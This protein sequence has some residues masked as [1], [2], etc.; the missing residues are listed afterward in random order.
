MTPRPAS[1]PRWLTTRR[2]RRPDDDRA[3]HP[4]AG[5]TTSAARGRGEG[6]DRRGPTHRR[7]RCGR[8]LHAQEAVELVKDE[9][10]TRFE[11][12]ER[13]DL[14]RGFLPHRLREAG[15]IARADDR[16]ASV[17]QVAPPLNSDAGLLDEIVDRLGD[18]LTDAGAHVRLG[19]TAGAV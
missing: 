10:S 18:V 7:P 13:D 4:H 6:L 14:L 16:G 15:L 2:S 8:L 3:L 9:D 5:Q 1:W 12:A 11:P 17:V 19:T